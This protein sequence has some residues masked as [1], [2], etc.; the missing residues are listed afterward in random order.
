[1]STTDGAALCATSGCTSSEQRV[2][3]DQLLFGDR[4]PNHRT[5]DRAALNATSCSQ[6]LRGLGAMRQTP[7]PTSSGQRVG[8]AQL[9][10]R[11][12]ALHHR[13]DGDALSASSPSNPSGLGVVPRSSAT[14]SSEQ[15]VGMTQLLLGDRPLNHQRC[16][17]A[18]S[19]TVGAALCATSG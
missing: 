4:D 14:S 10:F 15:R 16:G 8:D 3:M 12:W 11:D 6:P 18:L 7:A 1:M 2:S 19:T 9:L 17:A 5:T 13:L